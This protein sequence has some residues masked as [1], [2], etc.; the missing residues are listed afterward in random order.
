[1][2]FNHVSKIASRVGNLTRRVKAKYLVVASATLIPFVAHAQTAPDLGVVL[3]AFLA[4]IIAGASLT[5]AKI[6]PL[7]ALAWGVALA[8]RWVQKSSRS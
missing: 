4:S 7:L 3:D 1:M 8:W 6:G 2:K 5:F